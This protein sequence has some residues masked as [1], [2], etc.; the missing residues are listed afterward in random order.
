MHLGIDQGTCYSSA[1]LVVNGVLKLVQEPIRHGYSY[2]S[3][4]F[5]T[6][7]GEILIGQAAENRR[8]MHPTRYRREIKRELGRN[9]PLLIGDRE[10][11]PEELIAE[12]LRRFK[13]EAETMVNQKLDDAV[14]TVPA[15]YQ[16]YKRELMEKAAKKAGFT[17]VKLLAEPVAAALYYAHQ[18]DRSLEDGD[19]TL[20]YDLGGGTFDAALIQKRGATYELIALPVGDENCGGY[21]FDRQI[22]QDLNAKCSAPL[23]ELLNPKR[24]HEEAYRARLLV[25]DWCRDFKH[26]L[27]EEREYENFIP[28][29]GGEI[30]SLSR[31]QF[32]GM[33]KPFVEKTCQLCE[34]LVKDAGLSWERCDRVLMVGGSCRIPYIKQVLE[35]EFGR[36]V[37]RVDEPELAVCLGAAIYGNYSNSELEGNTLQMNNQQLLLEKDLSTTSVCY[38]QP[39]IDPF[40]AFMNLTKNKKTS[41]K[42]SSDPF[43]AF[44]S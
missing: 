2:P 41:H 43:S 16:A 13:S 34:Q 14:I 25:A 31:Q 15:V 9:T 26:Q 24:R 27:S 7:E 40:D 38:S 23:R 39:G 44:D 32:E 10:F 4:V 36:P 22:Y 3:S 29:G 5:V 19:I 6:P 28:V 33:I 8:Q 42:Q 21:D 12:F 35:Q 17:T 11:F 18:S 37:V 20:V 1:A 30:Y